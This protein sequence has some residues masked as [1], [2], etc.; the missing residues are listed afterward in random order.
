ML[1][2]FIL[3]FLF[4]VDV[5]IKEEKTCFFSSLEKTAG[6]EEIYAVS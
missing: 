4:P 5:A 2:V 1:V 6:G 3:G